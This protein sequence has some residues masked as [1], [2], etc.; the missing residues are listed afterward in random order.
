MRKFVFA[1]ILPTLLLPWFLLNPGISKVEAQENVSGSNGTG[2]IGW[3]DI[4]VP[5][6]GDIVA[7][8]VTVAFFAAALF[9]LIQ[10]VIG[11]ISWTNAGGDAKA[12]EAART[13]LT[14]AL[15]GLLIVVAA[16]AVSVIVTTV[17]GINIF[18]EEGVTIP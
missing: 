12:L 11:G 2:R 1:S 13:R 15:I 17:L 10:V 9:F 4:D 5:P 16:F 8:L 7:G 3:I 14:N 18:G 6:L